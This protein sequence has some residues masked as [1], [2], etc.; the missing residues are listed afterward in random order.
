MESRIVINNDKVQK[1]VHL[2]WNDPYTLW[3][4]IDNTLLKEIKGT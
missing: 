3:N 4:E 2:A 1:P